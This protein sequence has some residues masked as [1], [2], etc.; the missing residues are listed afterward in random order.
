MILITLRREDLRT[1]VEIAGRLDEGHLAELQDQCAAAAT[2][3]MVF[4]LSDLRGADPAAVEWLGER[5][6]RGAEI[7]GASP[8]IKLLLEREQQRLDSPAASGGRSS[9]ERDH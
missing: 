9:D 8:Y 1:I 5:S 2:T 6:T 4:D 3:K 7:R